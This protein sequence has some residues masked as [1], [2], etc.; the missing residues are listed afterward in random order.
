MIIV[1]CGPPGA[2][3]TTVANLLADRLE[4]RDFSIQV[5]DSDQFSRDTYDRMYERV[6][7]SDE[8][9]IVAGTF[10]KQQWQEQFRSLDD[11]TIVYLKADLKTCLDRNRQREN[12]LDEAA[13]HIVWREFVQPD[14]DIKVNVTERSPRE[15]VDR[16]VAELKTLPEDQQPLELNSDSDP[17]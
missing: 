1:I 9:W 4:E 14:A 12:P 6:T 3:K 11:V 5:L 15:I 16:I 10:Y 7:D 2:G 8:H 13:V 17:R